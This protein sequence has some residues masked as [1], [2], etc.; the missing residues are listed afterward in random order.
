MPLKGSYWILP[1]VCQFFISLSI[2]SPNLIS[3][4]SAMNVNG[5]SVSLPSGSPSYAAI[6]T[7]TTLVGGPSAYIAQLFAQIP[8]SAAASGTF[9]GYYTYREFFP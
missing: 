9:E 6:D 1:L 3:S 5:Q 8:G 7:G 4:L 2:L